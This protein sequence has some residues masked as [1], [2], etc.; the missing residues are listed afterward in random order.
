MPESIQQRLERLEAKVAKLER[1]DHKY[2]QVGGRNT[3]YRTFF[4]G[5]NAY[6]RCVKCGRRERC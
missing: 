3:N 5:C 1:C 4:N 2:E 6:I